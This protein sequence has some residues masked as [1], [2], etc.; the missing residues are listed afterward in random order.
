MVASQ[1][2]VGLLYIV[3]NYAWTTFTFLHGT[4]VAALA[5]H[6]SL[7][8]A[9]M[10]NAGPCHR[11]L[12]THFH[13]CL[14]PSNVEVSPCHCGYSDCIAIAGLCFILS[15]TWAMNPFMLPLWLGHC[16]WRSG[17]APSELLFLGLCLALSPE[18]PNQYQ[19]MP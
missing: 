1:W 16:G 6:L 15:W 19:A 2:L 9:C 14:D 12:R 8:L 3:W 17:L 18:N 4:A 11:G 7:R 5:N 13:C 10:V